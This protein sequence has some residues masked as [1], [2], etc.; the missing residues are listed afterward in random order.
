MLG[1]FHLFLISLI[2]L[3]KVNACDM[4]L[5]CNVGREPNFFNSLFRRPKLYLNISDM[6]SKVKGNNKNQENSIKC[7]AV[8]DGTVGEYCKFNRRW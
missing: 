1:S 8:G 7:V 4:D 2:L 5:L 6:T 3:I